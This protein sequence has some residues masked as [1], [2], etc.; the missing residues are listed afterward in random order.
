MPNYLGSQAQFQQKYRRFLVARKECDS[1]VEFRQEDQA[2][3]VLEELHQA[4]LPFILRR[5]K[6]QVAPTL[7]PLIIQDVPCPLNEVQWALYNAQFP[8]KTQEEQ[9]IHRRMLHL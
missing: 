1:A 2:I 8:K 5:T 6:S 3:K 7:P 4:V 9:N